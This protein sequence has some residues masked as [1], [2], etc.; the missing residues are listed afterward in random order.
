MNETFYLVC[1]LMHGNLIEVLS[2]VMERF[3]IMLRQFVQQLLQLQHS[4]FRVLRAIRRD[5]RIVQICILTNK[6]TE[7][8]T[9]PL[10]DN[11]YIL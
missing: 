8:T 9:D 5:N 7:M 4:P 1:I 10:N 2:H 6:N 3:K 11:V